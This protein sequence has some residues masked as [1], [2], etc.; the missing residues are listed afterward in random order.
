[1]ANN[2]YYG[3]ASGVSD[4]VG[5]MD[6]ESDRQAKKSQQKQAGQFSDLKMDKIRGEMEKE[7]SKAALQSLIM[8]DTEGAMEKYNSKGDDKMTE[9]QLN[10][11]TGMVTWTDGK[12]SEQVAMLPQLMAMSGLDPRQLDTPDKKTWSR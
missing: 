1:M 9:L 12:G 4:F 7:N 8:G 5:G 10:P 3:I 11:D 6:A 2:E